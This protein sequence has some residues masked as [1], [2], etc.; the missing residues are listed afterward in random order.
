MNA[1]EAIKLRQGRLEVRFSKTAQISFT[2][3]SNMSWIEDA[4]ARCYP[5]HAT[6]GITLK[7]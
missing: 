3:R 2:N 1:A 7:R 5:K 4:M 6:K